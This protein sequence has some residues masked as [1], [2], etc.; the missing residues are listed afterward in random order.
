MLT[1]RV[2]H[3]S[4]LDEFIDQVQ[5]R[6]EVAGLIMMGSAARGAPGPYS[7][8]DLLLVFETLPAPL[9]VGLTWIDGRLTDLIFVMAAEIDQLVTGGPRAAFAE[10]MTGRLITW[11][12]DGRIMLDRSGRLAHAQEVV[13]SAG[14][15]RGP[16]WG[17]QYRIWFS[18]NYD[19]AQ[20]RRCAAN[21]DPAAQAVVDVRLLFGL[22]NVWFAYFQLRGLPQFGKEA[23]RYLAEHDQPFQALFE[24]AAGEPDRSRR[25]MLYVELVTQAVATFGKAWPAE[26]TALQFQDGTEIEPANVQAAQDWWEDLSGMAG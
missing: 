3:S 2:T 26:T 13:R 6:P 17:E 19:L 20:T 21:P 16:T 5:S 7:D 4:K 9:S 24:R 11:L 22:S 25:L 23:A 14:W 1:A 10:G 8:Y 15:T 18:L 12:R